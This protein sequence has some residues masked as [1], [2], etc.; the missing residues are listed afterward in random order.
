MVRITLDDVRVTGRDAQGVIVWRD[1]E[2]D[3]YVVSI[4]CF[5]ETLQNRAES[6]GDE[7]VDGGHGTNSANGTNGANGGNGA[8]APE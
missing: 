8:S 7:S 2:P 1:R 4:A 5:Q 6:S 3:D